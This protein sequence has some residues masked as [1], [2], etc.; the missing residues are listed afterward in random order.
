MPINKISVVADGWI[1]CRCNFYTAINFFER[2]KKF[3]FE[4]GINVMKGGIDSDI[5]AVSYLLSMY[6]KKGE[7]IILTEQSQVKVDDK[8]ISLDE[9]MK[10]SCYM[11]PC[12]PLF[13][14]KKN[15]GKLLEQSADAKKIFQLSENR[16]DRAV[17]QV[18][19]EYFRT[20]AAIGYAHGKDIFC[21]P[22][23][24][25]KRMDYYQ[26]NITYAIDMLAE[27]KKIVIL[28]LEK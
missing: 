11:D 9:L 2:Y 19:N 4:Q 15:V 21:F 3:T 26:K 12:Y 5:W 20:M 8:N 23:M 14:T 10:Y 25:K 7:N 27:L 16:C 22:W 1:Q 13:N 18:G 17:N 28:P 6:N 24:S